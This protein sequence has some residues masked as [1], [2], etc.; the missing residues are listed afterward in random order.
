V[1]AESVRLLQLPSQPAQEA[2]L[3]RAAYRLKDQICSLRSMM[4]PSRS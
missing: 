2:H 1:L 3:G 4:K